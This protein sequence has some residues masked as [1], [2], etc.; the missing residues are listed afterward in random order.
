MIKD[1][2]KYYWTLFKR[3]ILRDKFLLEHKR[4]LSDNGE[5]KKVDFELNKN[6]IV[7]DVG[8]FNGDY[9]YEIFN[10]Y[11]CN[12]YVFEIAPN[13]ISKLNQRFKNYP[14]IKIFEYGLSNESTS[15]YININGD[16]TSVENIGDVKV[17]LK[18]FNEVFKENKLHFIDLIKINI[19]GGEYELLKNIIESNNQKNVGIFLI[20]F[21]NFI[22]DYRQK[23]IRIRDLLSRTHYLEFNYECIWE[24][25]KI[26]LNH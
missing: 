2:I 22:P 3:N 21:H 17:I 4:F 24:C 15:K 8:G 7:F 10:K 20:Q 16:S 6:S 23:I 14:K 13:F 25:W 19:E 11:N 18:T 5:K 26:K 12:V 1:Y 9:A